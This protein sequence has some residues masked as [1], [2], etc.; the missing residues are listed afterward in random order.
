MKDELQP[1]RCA[2]L[3][4]ALAA[5]ER[6]R[7]I[8]FLGA[9]PRNVTEIAEMLNTALVNASHHLSVL[10][11]AKL[12]AA[13]KQGRFVLYSLKPGVLKLD[14]VQASKEHIELGCCR[15]EIPRP[16]DPTNPLHVL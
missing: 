6:L 16:E 14:E 9:G 15:L 12:V 10:R 13:K 11:Q 1:Q 4:S 5:P 2:K 8:R 3:L 7:I